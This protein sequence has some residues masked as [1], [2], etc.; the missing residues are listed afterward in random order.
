MLNTLFWTKSEFPPNERP[1]QQSLETKFSFSD[2][3]HK[4]Q[5]AH[6]LFFA[7]PGPIGHPL[8]PALSKTP[9]KCKWRPWRHEQGAKPSNI[10]SVYSARCT[11]LAH[12]TRAGRGCLFWTNTGS[13]PDIWGEGE[14]GEGGGRGGGRRRN[15]TMLCSFLRFSLLP[16]PTPPPPPPSQPNLPSPPPTTTIH[17]ARFALIWSN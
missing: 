12:L 8:H 7:P 15:T 10:K 2:R 14:G 1:A 5:Y 11:S 13:P 6:P 4:V 17:A 9:K 3:G 16:P